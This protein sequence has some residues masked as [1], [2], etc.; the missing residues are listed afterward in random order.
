LSSA[1]VGDLVLEASRVRAA[2]KAINK[3]R[4]RDLSQFGLDSS[5]LFA[6]GKLAPHQDSSSSSLPSAL[7]RKAQDHRS[8]EFHPGKSDRRAKSSSSSSPPNAR[9]SSATDPVDPP[10]KIVFRSPSSPQSPSLPHLVNC[11]SGTVSHWGRD[12]VLVTQMLKA[13]REQFPKLQELPDH[14]ILPVL[15]TAR[16]GEASFL[17]Y[18]PA[19]ASESLKRALRTWHDKNEYKKYR[20]EK[21]P[22]FC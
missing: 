4:K 9:K 15:L 20:V 17:R 7:K 19:H 21:P 14:D 2:I 12:Y 8:V 18:A 5:S 11:T 6:P 16:N 3:D 13:F 10:R 1:P 22:D